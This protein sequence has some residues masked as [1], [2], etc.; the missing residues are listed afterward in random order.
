[1]KVKVSFKYDCEITLKD[2]EVINIKK[3][4]DENYADELTRGINEM[5]LA[6]DGRTEVGCVSDFKYKVEDGE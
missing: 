5:L 1:M 4:L 3:R 6:G 2:D